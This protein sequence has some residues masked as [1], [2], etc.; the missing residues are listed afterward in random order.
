MVGFGVLVSNIHFPQLLLHRFNGLQ[1]T[2]HVCLWSPKKVQWPLRNP[3]GT[4]MS[5]FRQWWDAVESC[6]YWILHMLSSSIFNIECAMIFAA[7]EFWGHQKKAKSNS[8]YVSCPP[9]MLHNFT[10]ELKICHML[11]CKLQIVV[12]G[13][14]C[15]GWITRF[16][17]QPLLSHA[18]AQENEDIPT[19]KAR[20]QATKVD[21]SFSSK[22]VKNWKAPTTTHFKASGWFEITVA[23][24]LT[25]ANCQVRKCLWSNMTTCHRNANL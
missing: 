8:W 14:F 22:L 25:T 12:F 9:H 5:Y 19:W 6:E 18:E 3:H 15:M 1:F 16:E 7:S 11:P 13:W 10:W 23:L 21:W 2:F 20:F 24:A 17:R 4:K